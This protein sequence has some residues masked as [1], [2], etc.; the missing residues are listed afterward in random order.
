M[1]DIHKPIIGTIFFA[2]GMVFCLILFRIYDRFSDIEVETWQQMI[3]TIM[4]AIAIMQLATAYCIIFSKP[5]PDR[6]LIFIAAFNLVI[7]PIGTVAGIYYFWYYF[8]FEL[9]ARKTLK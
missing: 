7:F 8:K 2:I 1:R 3:F 9:F 5:W 6:I 4:T